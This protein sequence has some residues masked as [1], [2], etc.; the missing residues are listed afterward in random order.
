MGVDYP[1]DHNAFPDQAPGIEG[2]RS[3]IEGFFEIFAN[4]KRRVQKASSIILAYHI[5]SDF[6]KLP[7]HHDGF[8]NVLSRFKGLGTCAFNERKLL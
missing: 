6:V 8:Q 1:V 4:L 5:R 2:I 3:A 7:M